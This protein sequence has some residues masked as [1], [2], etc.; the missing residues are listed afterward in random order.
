MFFPIFP[1]FG[2][3]Q[4]LDRMQSIEIDLTVY[5]DAIFSEAVVKLPILVIET[6]DGVIIRSKSAIGD[7]KNSLRFTYNVKPAEVHW[8]IL[9]EAVIELDNGKTLRIPRFRLELVDE[10]IVNWNESIA[11]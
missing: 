8:F 4:D 10:F 11:P 2:G 3:I 9:P 6:S 7:E 1:Y 5:S